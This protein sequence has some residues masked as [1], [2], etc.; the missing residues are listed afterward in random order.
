M[1]SPHPR[2]SILDIDVYVPGK[3]GSSYLEGPVYKLSSNETPFGPSPQAVEAYR[4]ASSQLYLYPDGTARH[5]REAIGE[6][7]AINPEQIVCGNGSDDLLHLLATAYLHEGDESISTEHGFLVYKI[8]TLA[9]GGKPVIAREKGECADVDTILAHIT[10]KTKLIFLANPNNPT[11]TYLS[12]SEIERLHAG[13]RKDI[14]LVLDEAYAEYAEVAAKPGYASALQLVQHHHNI[15]VTR[16]FSKIYGLAGLRIGWCYA[17]PEICTTLHRIRG[18][19]NVNG[20]AIE[21]G[22]AAIADRTHLE[23]AATHNAIW[24]ET[25]TRELSALGLRVTPSVANFLLVHFN[26]EGLHTAPAAAYYLEQN[27]VIVRQVGAYGFPCALRIT[28][29]SEVA[30]NRVI[31]LLREFLARTT[32][33]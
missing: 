10:E 31:A 28:I 32:P 22:K 1:T 13:L 33:L 14:L 21:A 11:G 23:K 3:S 8:A 25:L 27:G 26:H 19:F 24:I 20:P 5:L 29:G 9:A 16:T 4:Q 30:N 2:T 17:S 6:I 18:P 7:H 12:L 15:V